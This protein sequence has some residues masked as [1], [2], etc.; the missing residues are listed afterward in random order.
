MIPVVD[1]WR[2]SDTAGSAA[3]SR[4]GEASRGAAACAGRRRGRRPMRAD[5]AYQK[6]FLSQFDQPA[7]SSTAEAMPTQGEGESGD[8]QIT[9]ILQNWANLSDPAAQLLPLVYDRLRALAGR[10]MNGER[11][12]HT[13][14]PTA[15][16]HEAFMKLV[17]L[18]ESGL[19]F[20]NRG[21]F[22]GA[23]AEAMR[24]ILIDYARHRI[25]T[26]GKARRPSLDEL[27]HDPPDLAD[28]PD[29]DLLLALDE[30]LTTLARD[31]HRAAEVVRLR[32]FAGLG[33]AETAE[34]M[35][36]SLRTVH[37]EWTYARARLH[38]ML[39]DA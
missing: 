1:R 2:H 15:L 38:E 34:A 11:R 33:A 32:Y 39:R 35:G 16:V 4:R 22:F 13:L 20:E 29:P 28:L 37:R 3:P 17:R 9:R 12:D 18:P 31:D 30:A 14:Q 27:M 23:A 21:R 26:R 6:P 25:A 7:P 24:R 8:P 10:R 36:L 5:A 19:V